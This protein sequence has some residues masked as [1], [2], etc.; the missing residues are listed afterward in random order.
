MQI[1]PIHI[2]DD[3]KSH[4]KLDMLI[5][6]SL[7]QGQQNIIDHDILVIAHKIVSKAEGRIIDLQ[8]VKPS[9]KSLAIAKEN[10]KDPRIV[11]TILNESK[12]IVRLSRG[13]IIAETKHGFICANAGVDQSNVEDS[14]NHAVLLPKDADASAKKIRNSLR[15]KT[16]KD[17]AVIITDTFG[18]PFR[19]GQTNVAIG[20]DGIN[21]IKSY[22]GSTDMYGKK[23]RVTEIAVADEIA[24]AAEL[25]MGKLERVPLVIIRG[26]KYHVLHKKS[27]SVSKL[28]RPKEKDLFR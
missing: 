3:I 24:S 14:F 7:R 13:I 5:L 27:A 20:V 1:I 21:P 17:V 25:A 10:G 28:I 6:K 16:G 8:S 22:I 11:Q 18:R 19:E 12:E 9:V 4:D 2:L 15:K 23:L 26:Y